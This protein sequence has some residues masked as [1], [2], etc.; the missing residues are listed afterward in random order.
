[1]RCLLTGIKHSPNPSFLSSWM[2]PNPGQ[3]HFI[4]GLK[5]LSYND[6]SWYIPKSSWHQT[7][8]HSDLLVVSMTLSPLLNDS[9]VKSLHTIFQLWQHPWMKTIH[10]TET[11]LWRWESHEKEMN[12]SQ[13]SQNTPGSSG[14]R[15]K[16]KSSLCTHDMVRSWT[17]YDWTDAW[18][19]PKTSTSQHAFWC[20][21]PL[22]LPLHQLRST[23]FWSFD[24]WRTTRV[25]LSVDLN[26]F[27]HRS[28]SPYQRRGSLVAAKVSTKHEC[29]ISVYKFRL[30]KLEY[31]KLCPKQPK[32]I[33]DMMD[34]D[35]QGGNT[36]HI[37]QITSWY[38][39]VPWT[40]QIHRAST[41]RS[42]KCSV[43]RPLPFASSVL[44]PEGVRKTNAWKMNKHRQTMGRRNGY[45]RSHFSQVCVAKGR[46]A[47]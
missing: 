43:S 30:F 25:L 15:R 41:P 39:F 4:K 18:S 32:S 24:T 13:L 14:G 47:V 22:P 35:Q 37:F 28:V 12:I 21:T 2:W 36:I 7:S 17:K 20:V 9:L 46:H 3:D 27:Q 42:W 40:P 34:E 19:S 38:T 11:I 5:S 16:V 44:H 33:T 45:K 23:T 26:R 8:I 10:E 6:T 31:L 1:M 29:E